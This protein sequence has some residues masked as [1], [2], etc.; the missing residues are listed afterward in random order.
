M[1]MVLTSGSRKKNVSL[2]GLG[3][4]GV[5]LAIVIVICSGNNSIGA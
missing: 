3:L 4:V 2:Q 1:L 5:I